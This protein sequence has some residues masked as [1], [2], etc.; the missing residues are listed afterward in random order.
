LPFNYSVPEAA[1]QMA[2]LGHSCFFCKAG[3]CSALTRRGKSNDLLFD[4]RFKPVMAAASLV[5]L[6]SNLKAVLRI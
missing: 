4:S 3:C 1:F 5:V 2:C 6:E